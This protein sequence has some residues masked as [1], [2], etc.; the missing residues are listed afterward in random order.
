MTRAAR[1]RRVFVVEE[2][3]RCAGPATMQREMV[4]NGVTVVRPHIPFEAGLADLVH[5]QRLLLDVWCNEDAVDPGTLW[6]YTPQ[7]LPFSSHLRAKLTVYDCMDELTAFAGARPE[8]KLLERQLLAR[9]DVVFTGG[10]SLWEAKRSLHHNVH[11]MPSSVDAE[12]FRA[13]RTLTSEPADQRDIPHPRIGYC[14]VIDERLD[15][16]LIAEMAESRPEWHFVFVGPVTKIS[17]LSLPKGANLHYLG[18][19]DYS[20]LPAYLAAWDVAMLPFARNEAT[21]FISPTKTPEY[22]AAGRHVVSTPICDVVRTWGARGMVRIAETPDAFVD[23]IAR[24]LRDADPNRLARVDRE[25]AD[26]TWD[27][28]WR[29]MQDAMAN[30]ALRVA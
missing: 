29:R 10:Y 5:V 3:V 8:L 6:Y 12:H 28:T 20:E 11:A 19:R 18:A 21:R 4:H 24:A 27:H 9:A 30:A 16:S 7:A 15:L 17:V 26:D 25:L 1:D 14:G 13:A 23:A 2:P 22:L